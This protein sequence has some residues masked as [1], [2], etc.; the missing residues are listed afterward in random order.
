MGSGSAA[1]FWLLLLAVRSTEAV[2]A[3]GVNFG[4]KLNSVDEM[5]WLWQRAVWIGAQ[6][7]E[8]AAIAVGHK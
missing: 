7:L 4:A 2:A 6:F 1:E 8:R 3:Q 5:M